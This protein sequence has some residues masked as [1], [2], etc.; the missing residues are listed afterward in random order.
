MA[1]MNQCKQL[2]LSSEGVISDRE[3]FNCLRKEKN[4]FFQSD[5]SERGRFT[6]FAISPYKNFRLN[7]GN[8]SVQLQEMEQEMKRFR[9]SQ[10]ALSSPFVGGA[11]GIVNFEYAYK[12][13]GVKRKNVD[14]EDH[15]FI[16]FYSEVVVVDR[17][18]GKT[19]YI[20]NDLGDGPFC[21]KSAYDRL[22]DLKK[23]I[24]L[25]RTDMKTAPLV[26]KLDHRPGEAHFKAMVE[27]IRLEIQQGN[28]FQCVVAEKREASYQGDAIELLRVCNDQ[29]KVAHVFYIQNGDKTIIGA[30]PELLVRVG[31]SGK[32]STC[33]IAGTRPRGK[34]PE[35]DQ[36]F[37]DELLSCEKEKAEHLMLVDLSRNDIGKVSRPRSVEV[38]EFQILKKFENVMHLVS[39]VEGIME[40]GKT[41]LDVFNACFPAGTLSGAPKTE[42]LYNI[43]KLEKGPRGAYGGALFTYDFTGVFVSIIA[44]RT[45]ELNKESI[46]YGVGAGIVADSSAVDEYKEICNKAKTVEKILVGV[47]L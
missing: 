45:L 15:G 36:R 8:S 13:N 21:R 32:I 47:Q 29:N 12:L 39:H 28:L 26:T 22:I 16:N 31:R 41:P 38:R 1:L 42:A 34:T 11:V 7:A 14:S 25:L 43:L 17:V 3:I 23:R 6:I 37:A 30:S 4:A 5:R 20:S 46:S 44:I 2:I 9:T 18:G 10:V 27:K 19:H 24:S 33:P 40:E 35:D